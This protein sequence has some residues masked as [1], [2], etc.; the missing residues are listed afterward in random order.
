MC[1]GYDMP[2]EPFYSFQGIAEELRLA[3][4]NGLARW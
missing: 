3:G 1:G 2:G 4:R